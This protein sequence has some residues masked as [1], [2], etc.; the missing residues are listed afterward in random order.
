MYAVITTHVG[1]RYPYVNTNYVQSYLQRMT[2]DQSIIQS[3]SILS[4]RTSRPCRINQTL[5][6]TNRP[7]GATLRIKGS[8]AS[9]RNV[10]IDLLAED[11]GLPPDF[12]S[13]IYTTPRVKSTIA[14]YSA[15][16]DFDPY[17]YG[18]FAY[19]R[20]PFLYAN[21]DMKLREK[22]LERGVSGYAPGFIN[23]GGVPRSGLFESFAEYS[24]GTVAPSTSLVTIRP[25]DNVQIGT[26]A[27]TARGC[28]EIAGILGYDIYRSFYGSLSC[29]VRG[30]LPL[31]NRPTAQYLF[32]PI[33]GNEHHV[34]LGAE[35]MGCWHYPLDMHECECFIF[36]GSCSVDHVFNNKQRRTFDLVGKPLSRYRMALKK[37]AY[38]VELSP[39]ANVTTMQVDVYA[40]C[41]IQLT[42]LWAYEKAEWYWAIGYNLYIQT[43]DIITPR[44]PSPFE[45]ERWVLVTEPSVILK[46]HDIDIHSGSSKKSI[47][48]LFSQAYYHIEG[49]FRIVPVIGFGGA[50][51]MGSAESASKSADSVGIIN[52]AF[53]NWNIWI[54]IGVSI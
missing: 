38:E 4:T 7:A 3:V 43:P 30:S 2:R 53:S 41:Q 36:Y 27:R 14:E 47:N 16:I 40:A 1:P 42:L 24:A 32:E 23:D 39:I 9:S 8:Q 49:G 29:A 6:G 50:I 26:R 19:V 35:L 45:T 28:P 25:L 18:L 31:G 22:I 11:Y 34:Q 5:F 15:F 33:V 46:G 21:W 17:I 10:H 20:V 52:S 48:T 44:S 54:S 12:E 13:L 37:N 51:E